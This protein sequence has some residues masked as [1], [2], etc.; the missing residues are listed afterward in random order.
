MINST[1]HN[2]NEVVIE[3]CKKS[4]NSNATYKRQP[5]YVVYVV[6]SM[7][8]AENF[9][10]DNP[11]YRE[12]LQAA[13]DFHIPIVIIVRANFTIISLNSSFN[14]GSIIYIIG[15]IIIYSKVRCKNIS[16]R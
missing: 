9:S 5:S 14:V 10:L 11:L 1:R 3:R 7:D 15:R 13:R 12:T 4:T 8:N 6:D 16:I 2:H